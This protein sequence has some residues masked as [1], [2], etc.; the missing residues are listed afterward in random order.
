VPINNLMEDAA[1]AEISRAQLWQ[2][3]RHKAKL[4]DGR[5]VTLDLVETVMADELSKL[6]EQLGPSRFASGKFARAAE[7]FQRMTE[8]ARF[9]EFLTSVAY[10][11][12]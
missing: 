5:T 3:V 1:T 7:L 6:R 10:R 9:P 8:N 2:W 12:L 4:A 11:D